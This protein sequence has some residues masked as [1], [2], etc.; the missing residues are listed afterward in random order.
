MRDANQRMIA[1]FVNPKPPRYVLAT[2]RLA[3]DHTTHGLAARIFT[4]LVG[5]LVGTTG[6][7]SLFE[8]ADEEGATSTST[9]DSSRAA[10][11]SVPPTTSPARTTSPPPPPSTLDPA[12]AA[13]NRLNIKVLEARHGSDHARIDPAI[14][15]M[16]HQRLQGDESEDGVHIVTS[17]N[18]LFKRTLE[19]AGIQACKDPEVVRELGLGASLIIDVSEDIVCPALPAT[20]SDAASSSAPPPGSRQRTETS[21][22]RSSSSSSDAALLARI[23][24]SATAAEYDH[25][26]DLL[27]STCSALTRTKIASI[28]VHLD[29]AFGTSSSLIESG[30]TLRGAIPIGS[31]VSCI[32][33]AALLIATR[34][35]K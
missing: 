31:G 15:Q 6:C 12:F 22:G 11:S 5:C 20:N 16:F 2:P 21:R 32:D 28:V 1:G 13:A 9:A 10:S 18:P 34:S 30:E 23:D 8:T 27:E 26:L 19:L 4:V 29:D 17:D 35:L 25:M 33:A 24:P 7:S 14:W 3:H